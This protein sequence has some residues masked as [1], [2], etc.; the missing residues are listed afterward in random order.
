VRATKSPAQ[1][2][3]YREQFPTAPFGALARVRLDEL[4]TQAAQAAP[5]V[6]PHDQVASLTPAA[7]APPPEQVE[8]S[9]GLSRDGR[10]RVQ[11]ALKLLGYDIGTPDGVFGPKSRTAISAWQTA[12][13][14]AASG[15]LTT[16]EHTALLAAA[17][18][19]LAAWGLQQH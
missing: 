6:P 13:G 11:V 9:I 15:Y 16:D 5:A 4:K 7:D 19:Q 1:Y 17:A 3:A 10:V 8:R 14:D 18:P 12:Q 2:E